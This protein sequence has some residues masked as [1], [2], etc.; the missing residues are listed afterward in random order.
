MGNGAS[1]GAP[2][3][4]SSPG[5]PPVFPSPTEKPSCSP[6]SRYRLSDESSEAL[7]KIAAKVNDSVT[8]PSPLLRERGKDDNSDVKP[9]NGTRERSSS[10]I[11]ELSPDGIKLPRMSSFSDD[12][13]DD[14]VDSANHLKI[15]MPKDPGRR[16]SVIS[17]EKQED[18]KREFDERLVNAL[19]LNLRDLLPQAGSDSK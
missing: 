9:L 7:R 17:P 18:A 16:T 4:G 14:K 19:K 10:A 11:S 6:L 15:A 1:V 3:P 13:D 5:R 8:A 12:S 2:S